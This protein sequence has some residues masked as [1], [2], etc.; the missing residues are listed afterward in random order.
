MDIDNLDKMIGRYI[1]TLKMMG[2]IMN[3]IQ[4]YQYTDQFTDI[5]KSFK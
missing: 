4:Y 2:K 1:M 3:R 5:L